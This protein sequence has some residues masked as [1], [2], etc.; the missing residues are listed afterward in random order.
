VAEALVMSADFAISSISSVLFT[1]FPVTW[2][3]AAILRHRVCAL[4]S[5][6]EKIRRPY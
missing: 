6:A 5:A 1:R 2:C 4:A 3:D